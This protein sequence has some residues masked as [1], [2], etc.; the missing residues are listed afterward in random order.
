[1]TPRGPKVART[2]T[3]SITISTRAEFTAADLRKRLRVPADAKLFVGTSDD[4][5]LAP[6]QTA[7]VAEWQVTR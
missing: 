3:K 5:E 6:N 7:I 4:G 1:V 2:V